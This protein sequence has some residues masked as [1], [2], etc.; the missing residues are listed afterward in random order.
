MVAASKLLLEYT[1]ATK[2]YIGLE[3]YVSCG[4]GLCGKC[5]LDGYRT[6]V[7]GPVMRLDQ[8]D[9]DGDFGNWQRNKCGAKVSV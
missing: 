3:R 9:F 4:V 6:C 7:D 2:I 8:L 5:A 1:G